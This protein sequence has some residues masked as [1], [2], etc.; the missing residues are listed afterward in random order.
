MT[1]REL[2]KER[3]LKG[4]KC[5]FESSR[6]SKEIFAMLLEIDSWWSGLFEE[7]I[8][9]K[10]QKLKDEFSFKAGRGA[11]YSKQK[12]IEL[13]PYKSIVWQVTESNLTFLKEVN[14]WVDTKIR[15]DLSTGK[16]GTK[17]T[18]THE[19]LVPQ[20]ECYKSCASAWT[21]YMENLEARLK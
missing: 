17:I 6:S 19:G 12:L 21:K 5:S 9:G 1:T 11:H 20:F 14:E 3:G 16:T 4:F 13:K 2:T 7:T 10:S 18:F 8:T 15:F